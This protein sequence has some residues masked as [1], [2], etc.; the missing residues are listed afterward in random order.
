[1]KHPV[2]KKYNLSQI[3]FCISGAAPLGAELIDLVASVLPNSVIGQGY[4][5]TETCSLSSIDPDARVVKVGSSGPLLPGIEA[6]IVKA[7]GTLGKEGERGELLV[8][9]PCVALGYVGNP[10]A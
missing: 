3:K 4:G 1:V 8:A 9:G 5:L 10:E 2:A 7:D 6:K